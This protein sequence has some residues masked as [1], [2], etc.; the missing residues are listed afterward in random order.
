[1]VR[2]GTIQSS[3]RVSARARGARSSGLFSL[4]V[5]TV[6][7][8]TA[9]LIFAILLLAFDK[10]LRFESRFSH[11]LQ[12]LSFIIISGFEYTMKKIKII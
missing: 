2:I 7:R 6:G 12:F 11:V 5:P 1:M 9:E 8:R 4:G 10:S 3:L